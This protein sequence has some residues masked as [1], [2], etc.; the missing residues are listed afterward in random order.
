[1]KRQASET[2]QIVSNLEA[3]ISQLQSMNVTPASHCLKKDRI[4]WSV[5]TDDAAEATIN[6]DIDTR[7]VTC[8]CCGMQEECTAEY[9]AGV[10]ALFCGRWVCGLCT[11]AVKEKMRTAPANA[12]GVRQALDSHAAF[13]KQFN[14]TTRLNPKLSLAGAMRDI[15][16]KSYQHRSS[17]GSARAPAVFS[18]TMSCGRSIMDVTA[19]ATP[20]FH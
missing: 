18:R 6:V 14:C 5:Y 2:M 13:C 7:Q 8:E 9:I 11:E 16:R 15:A 19:H 17:G 10:R 20:G 12:D 1:M 4:L 3:K